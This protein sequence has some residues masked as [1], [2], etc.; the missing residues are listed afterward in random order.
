M[1]CIVPYKGVAPT[2][3]PSA[4]IAPTASIVGDV[5]IGEGVSIWFGTVVRGDF[6]PVIIGKNTN[7]QDNATIHVMHHDPTVIGEGVIIGHNAI[8]HSHKIGDHTFIGM[9]S[10]IMGHV[11]VGENVVIYPGSLIEEHRKIP[12][13]SL[14]AGSP[15]RIIRALRDDEI[16]ALKG[17]ALRYHN[18]ADLY[19]N[20]LTR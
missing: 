4:F 8:I 16:A 19:K 6:Q 18:V 7:I 2:I 13:N 20:E 17:S 14:I 10:I 15:A 9:G 12:S 1:S 5:R 3:D 11:E